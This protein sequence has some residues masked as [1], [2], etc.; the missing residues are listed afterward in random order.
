MKKY[1]LNKSEVKFFF[2]KFDEWRNFFGSAEWDVDY[3][4]N[5]KLLEGEYYAA[6]GYNYKNKSATCFLN[7]E[8]SSKP[9]RR[10][11]DKI[12]YHEALEL[13]LA[14][15]SRFSDTDGIDKNEMQA[16]THT[17]I[18]KLEN[19]FFETYAKEKYK[20]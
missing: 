3:A 11:I 16:A 6:V 18:R 4:M 10:T 1:V 7:P 5:A 19:S 17:V 14:D 12:A 9:S 8:W 20:D 15:M 2:D 13:I